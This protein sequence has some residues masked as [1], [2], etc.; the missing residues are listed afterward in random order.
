VSN[1]GEDAV[2]PCTRRRQVQLGVPGVQ[3]EGAG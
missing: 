1:H 2:A 3:E